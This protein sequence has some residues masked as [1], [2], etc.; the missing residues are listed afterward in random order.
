MLSDVTNSG[1]N[2]NTAYYV[3]PGGSL[4][5][6][7]SD[8]AGTGF[9]RGVVSWC[10]TVT[11]NRSTITSV[12]RYGIEALVEDASVCVGGQAPVTMSYQGVGE[13]LAS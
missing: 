7:G 9:A 2:S 5:L 3:H 11:L 6:Q 12:R 13:Q 8:V 4:T 10:G 1:P